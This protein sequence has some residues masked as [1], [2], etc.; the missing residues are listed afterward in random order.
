MYHI[1]LS[2]GMCLLLP[3]I[4][5]SQSVK[6]SI[7]A[8]AAALGY[9]ATC[10][11]DEWA[12]HNNIGGLSKV[13]NAV[14]G[15]SFDSQPSFKPFNRLA[16]TIAVPV[17]V[18]VAGAGFFRFGDAVYSE[19][20]ISLGYSNTF[21]LATLGIKANYVQ[22]NVS[23][24]GTKGVF[25]I[26]FGG[27]ASL[28]NNLSIGAY[29][30]N[31]NQPEI[32]KDDG[33]KIPTLMMLGISFRLSPQTLIMTE[34]EKDLDYTL[35]WKTGVEYQPFKKFVF[36]TG[37]QLTPALLCFGFG[38]HP[39]KIRVDYAFQHNMESGSRHQATVAYHFGNK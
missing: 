21:G 38:Y 29:I 32:S 1:L 26:S 22:Y 14:V 31:L 13:K 3:C 33:E 5:V 39:Q 12:L 30:S 35:I 37:F 10:I 34:A 18:G 24:Y 19:Q 28:T 17:S 15:A 4:S 8:R 23:G 16:A 36:R 25:T 6:T 11:T 9:A 20:V 2:A 27:V 7:G